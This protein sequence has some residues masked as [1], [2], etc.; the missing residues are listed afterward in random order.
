MELILNW[1]ELKS[2]KIVRAKS[3]GS[4]L[5]IVSLLLPTIYVVAANYFGLNTAIFRLAT[6]FNIEEHWANLIPLS[7]EYLVFAVL[8]ASIVLLAYGFRG[9][10]NYL[11]PIVFAGVI[12]VLY[13][14]DNV[15]HWG[16]FTPFQIF[17][18]PTTWLA[19]KVLGLMGY[20]TQMTIASSSE[21]GTYPTLFVQNAKG[22]ADLQRRDSIVSEQKWY[23]LVAKN[24]LLRRWRNCHVLYQCSEDSHAVHNSNKHGR[25]L[26]SQCSGTTVS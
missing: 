13:T 2:E 15:Y 14:I 5:Y 1:E 20:T 6:S 18:T 23:S 7:T 11:L 3:L 10:K 21:Y 4:A 16:T 24:Q 17:V 25:R 26:Q 8:F 19:S 22:W 12:G 9:L